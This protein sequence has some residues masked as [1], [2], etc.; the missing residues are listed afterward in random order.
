MPNIL[1]ALAPAQWA[2][3]TG[4]K[5]KPAVGCHCHPSGGLRLLRGIDTRPSIE[6]EAKFKLKSFECKKGCDVKLFE[7]R[8]REK[9]EVWKRN[10]M[11]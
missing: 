4:M 7:I 6:A 5:N 8:S 10:L 3:T 1:A 2:P 11:M 9:S